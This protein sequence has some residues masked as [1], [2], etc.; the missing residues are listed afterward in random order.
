MSMSCLAMSL[1]LGIPIAQSAMATR[2]QNFVSDLSGK[3]FFDALLT[4]FGLIP[5][6]IILIAAIASKSRK[7]GMSLF[8]VWGYVVVYHFSIEGKKAGD[9]AFDYSAVQASE[10]GSLVV[11]VG[12]MVVVTG[13]LLYFGFLKGD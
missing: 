12:G 13:I 7:L 9:V 5:T 3:H 11:F 1:Y 10:T 8:A 6:A 2:W 4:P